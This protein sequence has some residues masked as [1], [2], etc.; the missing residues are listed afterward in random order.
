ML[1]EM[2]LCP[3]E[4]GGCKESMTQHSACAL[5]CCGPHSHFFQ[6]QYFSLAWPQPQEL[7]WCHWAH[8]RLQRPPGSLLPSPLLLVHRFMAVP[9]YSAAVTLLP[10]QEAVTPPT[11][12][13]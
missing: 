11:S 9:A 2:E 6:C 5:G 4:P 8:G 12:P 1:W 13:P 10:S 3:Q 7:L